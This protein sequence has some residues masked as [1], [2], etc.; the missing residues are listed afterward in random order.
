MSR[1]AEYLD[2]AWL[3]TG[4]AAQTPG[5]CWTAVQ[6]SFPSADGFM[7]ITDTACRAMTNFQELEPTKKL[8]ATYPDYQDRG[9]LCV[10]AASVDRTTTTTTAATTTTVTTTTTTAATTTTVTTTTT[11]AATTGSGLESMLAAGLVVCTFTN[12]ALYTEQDQCADH[13]PTSAHHRYKDYNVYVL[14]AE[15]ELRYAFT[16]QHWLD[17]WAGAHYWRGPTEVVHQGH[18]ANG[19]KQ[20]KNILTSES[21]FCV[22]WGYMHMEANFIAYNVETGVCSLYT[23]STCEDDNRY[24]S[25]TSRKLTMPMQERRAKFEEVMAAFWNETSLAWISLEWRSKR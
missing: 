21:G 12:C 9:G 4:S 13:S 2:S 6:A 15:H 1:W 17:Y 5:A 14:K 25:F 16:L 3:G 18:C 20:G 22:M 23:E 11:T 19:W 7:L 10:P 8:A 24:R